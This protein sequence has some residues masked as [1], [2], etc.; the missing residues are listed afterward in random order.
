LYFK[1]PLT[2]LTNQKT[3][4]AIIKKLP[5]HFRA[6]LTRYVTVLLDEDLYQFW[7]KET[8]NQNSSR[9]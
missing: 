4:P 2:Q 8:C 5:N 7:N 1:I 9:E 3:F 6:T